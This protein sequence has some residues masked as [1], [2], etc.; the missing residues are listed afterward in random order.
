[1]AVGAAFCNVAA[2]LVISACLALLSC[3]GTG[4]TPAVPAPPPETPHDA[5]VRIA[6]AIRRA[7]Y[8]DDREKLEALLEEMTPLTKAEGDADA[9]L[10]SRA[11]YWRGFGLWR[12]GWNGIV[13]G[14]AGGMTWAEI[15]ES[16]RGAV[17]EFEQSAKLD[18]PFVE[19]PIARLA[20]LESLAVT[21]PASE[22]P[23]EY[24][25]L[26]D[27]LA[28]AQK[29]APQN[30][31]L[32]WVFGN[33]KGDTPVKQGGGAE[34]AVQSF[35]EGLDWARKQTIADAA[36][37]AWGEAELLLGLTL[38]RLSAKPPNPDAADHYA[39]AALNI[40]PNW[41]YV[42][43]ILLP[44]IQAAREKANAPPSKPHP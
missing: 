7:A 43:D 8:A 34:K 27:L 25:R 14:D 32:A 19:A 6:A 44:Q 12:N 16:L 37:P 13:E 42:K 10:A 39:H 28:D 26:W 9:T 36:D 4:P 3:A 2:A 23:R 1:M 30:A 17:E 29:E 11:R 35:R 15:E 24:K 18:P 33:V 31:R 41:R 20:C 5:L 21:L 40:E 22:R 38:A